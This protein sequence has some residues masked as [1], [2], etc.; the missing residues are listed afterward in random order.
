[1]TPGTPLAPASELARSRRN[2]VLRGVALLNLTGIAVSWSRWFSG[3]AAHVGL[4]DRILGH[5]RL[6]GFRVDVIWLLLS[7]AILGLAFV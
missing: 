7:T 4:V 1:M 3:D 5:L 2:V 6:G